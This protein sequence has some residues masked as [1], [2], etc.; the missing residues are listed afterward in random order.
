MKYKF[1]YDSY[2]GKFFQITVIAKEEGILLIRFNKLFKNSNPNLHTKNALKEINDYFNGNLRDFTF[3]VVLNLT[4]FQRE[5]LNFIK[6]IPYGSTMSYREVAIKLGK[7]KSFRAVG[8][9]LKNNPLPLYFPCHRIIKSDG[10]LGGFAG[11]IRI[12]KELLEMEKK[13]INENK[14]KIV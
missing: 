2:G 4:P 8:Q 9:A 6:K 10:S 3:P 12:K 11:G 13:F 14:D 1:Y 5:V 7:P